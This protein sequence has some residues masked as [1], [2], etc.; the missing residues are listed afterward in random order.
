MHAKKTR[1]RKKCFLEASEK[2]IADMEAEAKILRTY[3]RSLKVISEEEIVELNERDEQS[4]KELAI[5]KLCWEREKVISCTRR[6][7]YLLIKNFLFFKFDVYQQRVEDS[8][9]AEEEFHSGSE[10]VYGTSDSEDNE[11]GS[12][13]GSND[14][15]SLEEDDLTGGDFNDGITI[16]ESTFSPEG[17]G[18]NCDMEYTS[19][20]H[21]QWNNH[22]RHNLRDWKKGCCGPISDEVKFNQ[23]M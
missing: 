14:S 17:S 8:D 20:R 12:W 23:R 19:N 10:E 4:R 21:A 9:Y 16:C 6:C 2:F 5:L 22:G 7:S 15:G 1:D 13:S 18:G 3:L 11:K